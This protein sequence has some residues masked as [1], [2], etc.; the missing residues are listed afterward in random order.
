ME[1]FKVAEKANKAFSEVNVAVLSGEQPFGFK[2]RKKK[3][4]EPVNVQ[5][6]INDLEPS[7]IEIALMDA[8]TMKIEKQNRDRPEVT[9]AADKSDEY[10]AMLVKSYSFWTSNIAMVTTPPNYAKK[11]AKGI[12]IGDAIKTLYEKYG[13]PAWTSNAVSSQFHVYQSPNIMFSTDSNGKV[14][15]WSLYQ[16]QK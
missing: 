16:I 2:R 4:K 1:A 15:S 7:L 10:S 13:Q 8:K 5:E 14:S 3:K 12:G 6:T 11:S 9:I